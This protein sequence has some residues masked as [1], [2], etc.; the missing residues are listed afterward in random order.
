[1]KLFLWC[2]VLKTKVT[3]IGKSGIMAINSLQTF[4]LE[5]NE[6]LILSL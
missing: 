3:F 4:F 5:W 2:A 6:H 1:M